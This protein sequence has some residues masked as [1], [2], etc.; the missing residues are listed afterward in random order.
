MVW[1]KKLLLMTFG[2][3]AVKRTTHACKSLMRSVLFRVILYSA[4]G[5]LSLI[6]S[7][8]VWMPLVFL[9]TVYRPNHPQEVLVRSSILRSALT[10][11]HQ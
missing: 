10:N 6:D 2:Q 7:L 9:L 3:R 1:S 5:M 8:F 11:T 4:L